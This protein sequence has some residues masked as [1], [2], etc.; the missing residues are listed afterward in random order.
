M[1]THYDLFSGIGGFA[2]AIDQVYGKENTKHIFVENDP[3]CQ[4]V[5]RKHWSDSEIHGD[6]RGFVA[7]TERQ[8]PHSEKNKQKLESKRGDKLRIEQ[9]RNTILTG[10]F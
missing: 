8:R 10:G 6:I 5:L 2:Y 3:F 1:I 4:A 9:S 7:D